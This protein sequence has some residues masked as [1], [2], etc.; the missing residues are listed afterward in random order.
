MNTDTPEKIDSHLDNVQIKQLIFKPGVARNIMIKIASTFIDGNPHWPD[1]IKFPEI[2]RKDKNCIGSAW[3]TL[4]NHG[5]IAQTAEIRRSKA[6]GRRGGIIL[7]YR[8]ENVN[9]LKRFLKANGWTE[10]PQG[11]LF[12]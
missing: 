1:E 12:A 3:R 5:M 2:E 9:L 4:M 6:D 10:K 7:K 11:E 8:P